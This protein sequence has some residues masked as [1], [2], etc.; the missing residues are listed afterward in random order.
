[1]ATTFQGVASACNNSQSCFVSN[2]DVLSWAK[3]ESTDASLPM[4][5]VLAQWI[6]ENAWYA[7]TIA[8]ECNNPGNVKYGE[9]SAPGCGA[10]DTTHNCM[11]S[12]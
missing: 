8:A 11:T 2:S 10:Y 3:T 5:L 6:A 4:D 9:H 1:M 7:G 12:Q